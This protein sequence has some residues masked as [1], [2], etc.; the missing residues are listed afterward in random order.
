MG[1]CQMEEMAFDRAPPS[2]DR[3]TVS[4][5]KEKVLTFMATRCMDKL[6]I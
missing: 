2:V 5:Q 6:K 4:Y 3:I 1:Y